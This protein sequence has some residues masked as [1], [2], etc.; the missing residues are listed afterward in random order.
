MS[1]M[2]I[3]RQ[4]A[5]S[6]YN[7]RVLLRSVCLLTSLLCS[8]LLT[9]QEAK[10]IDLSNEQQRTTLR[11]PPAKQPNCEPQPCV[12][13]RETSVGDCTTAVRPL[14]IA[15]DRVMPTDITLDPFQAEFRVLNTGTAS[16]EVPVSPHL[17]DLQ[18]PGELQAFPYL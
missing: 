8:V 3:Y 14:R 15:L 1:V 7:N 9:A 10:F 5:W 13:H 6:R 16:I 2:A 12:V 4:P 18:P 17:S 11:V